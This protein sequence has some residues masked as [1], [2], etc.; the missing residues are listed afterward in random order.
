MVRPR[1]KSRWEGLVVC[2]GTEMVRAQHHPRVA[3]LFRAA[4]HAQLD[5]SLAVVAYDAGT[6]PGGA[7][8][9]A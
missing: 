3:S 2:W 8:L 5:S 1:A 6:A 7:C 4:V 9:M